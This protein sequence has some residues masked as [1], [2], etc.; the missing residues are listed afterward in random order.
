MT[1][2]KEFL[3]ILY[4]VLLIAVLFL[5]FADCLLDFFL[6]FA[7][8]SGLRQFVQL[9]AEIEN[10]NVQ[11]TAKLKKKQNGWSKEQNARGKVL[12]VKSKPRALHPWLAYKCHHFI[13]DTIYAH[14]PLSYKQKKQSIRSK[15]RTNKKHVAPG[16]HCKI[17]KFIFKQEFQ[18]RRAF[19]N[20]FSCSQLGQVCDHY[21][22]FYQ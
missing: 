14:L 11:Q 18:V 19:M 15:K 7:S 10:R 13:K 17:H 20:I 9:L 12:K 21:V 8:L 2:L 6:S 1:N 3:W 16:F 5:L 22:F 4:C